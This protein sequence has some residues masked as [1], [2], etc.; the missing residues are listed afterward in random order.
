LQHVDGVLGRSLVVGYNPSSH[1]MPQTDSIRVFISHRD[2]TCAGCGEELGKGS[3]ITLEPDRD[4]VCLACADLDHL[5]YLPAGNAALTRR[6]REHS[7][8]SAVVLKWSRARKRNERQGLLVEEQALE[9]AEQECLADED[10]RARRRERE[11]E[12]RELLDQ[13]FVRQ[14]AARVRELFPRCPSGVELR[15]AEHACLKHSGRIG[16]TAAAKSFDEGA[17]RLAVVAHI[18]HEETA[19]DQLLA[20]GHDRQGAR[21]EVQGAIEDT[22]DAWQDE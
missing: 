11:A 9:R 4:A 16:R 18:R 13:E 2:N 5:I 8:L 6:A 21:W 3:W 14:F 15:I 22:L 12:R 10:A 20:Q 17:V 7:T 19:Y 1:V